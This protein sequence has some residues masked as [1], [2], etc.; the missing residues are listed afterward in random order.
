MVLNIGMWE[1]TFQELIQEEKP[2]VHWTLKLDGKL[3]LDYL[4]KGW[5]QY[6]QRAFGWFRCSSCQR[7]WASAQVQILCHMYCEHCMSQGQ[8]RMRLF[9]QRC[10]KC[11]RSQYEMPEFFPDSTM[12]ILNNLV[13]HILKTY[14][15][16]SRRKFKEMPVLLEVPLEG[17][18]DMANCEACALG[19]C[20][21]ALESCV[22]KPS[23]SPLFYLKIGRSSPQIGDV[24]YV[25]NQARNQLSEAKQ[26]KWDG[27]EGSGTCCCQD[28]LICVFILLFLF[29]II[30][31]CFSLE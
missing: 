7:S 4:A 19:Y 22:T 13:Q 5:K 17:S 26:A 16:G 9:A 31:K 27:S 2:W 6:Q 28:P 30:V 20:M 3:Q 11:S 1:Q 14:H 24:L 21:Q 12:R 29:F 25:Q 15:G 8:V 18:H 10:Q 23:K